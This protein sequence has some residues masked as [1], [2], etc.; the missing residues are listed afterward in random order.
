MKKF[1]KFFELVNEANDK[2]KSIYSVNRQLKSHKIKVEAIKNTGNGEY[3]L[4]VKSLKDPNIKGDIKYDSEEDV[5]LAAK[6]LK[7]VKD[8]MSFLNRNA[9]TMEG[10]AFGVILKD[11]KDAEN[12]ASDN[13]TGEDGLDGDLTGDEPAPEDTET[14]PNAEESADAEVDNK[15][16]KDGVDGE[17]EEDDEELDGDKADSD[18]TATSNDNKNP[19]I[20]IIV[21]K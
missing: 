20:Q 1:K 4:R 16:F 17:V 2:I 10:L 18:L 13:E 12:D 19:T 21:N 3:F 9:R 6:N 14:D 7:T 11:E 8:I 5:V 15:E